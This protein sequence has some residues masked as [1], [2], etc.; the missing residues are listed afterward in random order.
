MSQYFNIFI[1]ND[2]CKLLLSCS[3]YCHDYR[4]N[5]EYGLGY[6]WSPQHITVAVG[7]TVKWSW[8]GTTFGPMRNVAQVC[9]YV[10]LCMSVCNSVCNIT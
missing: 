3:W 8:T 5:E 4:Y 9:N 2:Y 1:Q 10:P 7:D 6:M